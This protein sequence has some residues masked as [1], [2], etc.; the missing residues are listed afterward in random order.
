MAFAT[1]SPARV[2]A[3]TGAAELLLLL[4]PLLL[5]PLLL[6]LLPLLVLLSRE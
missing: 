1:A 4:L 6:L 2:A 3:S 5:L